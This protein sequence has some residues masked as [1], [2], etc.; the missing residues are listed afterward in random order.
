MAK[1][2]RR[3]Y[4]EKRRAI[5]LATAAKEGLTAEGVQKRFG[6]KPVTYYSWR[7]KSGVRSG[8][9]SSADG[10]AQ[11]DSALQE[12][13]QARLRV[14]LPG[15]VSREVDSYLASYFGRISS[16]RRRIS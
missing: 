14:L 4:T 12:R 5:I 6:V 10:L 2:E 13:V 1:R 8:Q 7:K 16:R 11:I 15:I 9:G 3:I